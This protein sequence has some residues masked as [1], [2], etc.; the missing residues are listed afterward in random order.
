MAEKKKI[1]ETKVVHDGPFNFKD[2]YSF[3]YTLLGDSEYGVAE[4]SYKEKTKGDSKELEIHWEAKRKIDDYFQFFWKISIR[5]LG[6]KKTE[7]MKGG[8]KVSMDSGSLEIKIVGMLVSDYQEKWEGTP[9]L[10]FLRKVYD[11]FVV[12]K[13]A[14]EYEERIGEEVKDASDQLKAL[15]VLEGKR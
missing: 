9:L 5:V 8:R 10:K 2:F 6:L 15:L 3:F 1:I 7:V 13:T 14:K 11:N 12:K 4:K